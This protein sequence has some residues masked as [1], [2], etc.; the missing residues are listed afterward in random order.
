MTTATVLANGYLSLST[1]PR[2]RARRRLTLF[3]LRQSRTRVWRDN[4]SGN[5]PK[6]RGENGVDG[7]SEKGGTFKF[8]VTRCVYVRV[9]IKTYLRHRLILF[10]HIFRRP[11]VRDFHRPRQHTTT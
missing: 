7:G 2:T 1:V 8:N 3:R 4:I 6:R 9:N 10:A 5:A 11:I